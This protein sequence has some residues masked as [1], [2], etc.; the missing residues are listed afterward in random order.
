MKGIFVLACFF[1]T[2]T[3]VA[4]AFPSPAS[5]ES[6]K[7]SGSDEA[8]IG[9]A[10]MTST[11]SAPSTVLIYT[12]DSMKDDLQPTASNSAI[13]SGSATAS[14]PWIPSPE[15]TA[16]FASDPGLLERKLDLAMRKLLK[17]PSSMTIKIVA[18]DPVAASK[19]NLRE[20]FIHEEEGQIDSLVIFK[21]DIQF[22]DVQ[23]D[24]TKLLKEEKIDSKSVK[25]INMDVIIREVDLNAFL[26]VKAKKIKVDDP[27]VKLMKDRM[28]LEGTT[29]YSFV[30]VKFFASGGFSIHDSREVWFH[31]K[32]LKVNQLVMPRAFVGTI[33][34]KINPGL[35]L[36]KFPFRL[37]LKEIRIEQGSLHFTS[38][39][40]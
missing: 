30:K 39:R 31:P 29:R 14:P 2:A 24:T 19:G 4:C 32:K 27:K 15:V 40:Q 9:S 20:V 28:D 38:F 3:L 22:L 35:N 17:N 37:N 7:I 21:A 33:V 36:D 34:K 8:I 11:G 1:I 25:S 16:V 18:S 23:L 10:S 26:A 6:T 13:S 12:G 5:G